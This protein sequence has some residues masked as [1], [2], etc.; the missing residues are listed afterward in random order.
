MINKDKE[1]RLPEMKKSR[2]DLS[3]RLKRRN[4]VFNI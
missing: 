1:R 3:R 2:V 4:G